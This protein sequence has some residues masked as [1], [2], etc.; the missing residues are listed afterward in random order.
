MCRATSRGTAGGLHT[1]DDEIAS[2][3]PYEQENEN[4]PN[5]AIDW[6]DSGT[7]INVAESAQDFKNIPTG[8][9]VT[10]QNRV[11]PKPSKTPVIK[12]S[13]LF[14]TYT[15]FFRVHRAF[16]SLRIWGISAV[17]PG[18]VFNICTI[19]PHWSNH[20][21]CDCLFC[22]IS[23]DG[24][25]I[26]NSSMADGSGPMRCNPGIGILCIQHAVGSLHHPRICSDVPGNPAGCNDNQSKGA[27][28]RVGPYL[29]C[30]M[31]WATE[32]V[33]VNP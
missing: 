11:S 10:G 5:I 3:K 6:D 22:D 23:R 2:I 21:G 20:V 13:E 25:R 4:P 18:V 17:C 26:W 19:P 8:S 33:L 30:D 9:S 15:S 29:S 16:S 27:S 28:L 14:A 7:G 12:E 31:S 1:G 24:S 32:P